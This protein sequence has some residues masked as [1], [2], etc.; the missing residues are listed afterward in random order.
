MGREYLRDFF[1]K[2]IQ[3]TPE[4]AIVVNKK[5]L[6]CRL[7]VAVSEGIGVRNSTGGVYITTRCLKHLFDKKPAEEF[8]FLLDN[9]WQIVRYPDKIYLNKDA[10][11]GYFCFI[12]NLEGVKYFCSVEVNK[13]PVVFLDEKICDSSEN[14]DIEIEKNEIVEVEEIQVATAFRLRDEKYI[15][16]YTLLWDWGIGDPHRSA[17]DTP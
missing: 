12:K 7:T 8:F 15:K 5:L 6:L 2:Y 3:G 1:I 17:L 13:M 9:L 11:R 16:N 4:K 10:K 14:I